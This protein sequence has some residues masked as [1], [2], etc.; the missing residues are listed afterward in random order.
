MVFV[1]TWNRGEARLWK[2]F[3]FGGFVGYFVLLILLALANYII[4][5]LINDEAGLIADIVG[6]VMIFVY[7]AWLLV[8]IWRC[9]FNVDW[10]IWGYLVRV[11]VIV[12]IAVVL[13]LVG[14]GLFMLWESL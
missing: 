8:V 9:A 11:V 10:V 4:T 1:K 5:L 6:N 3:W 7:T 2:P 12:E 13:P 14:F